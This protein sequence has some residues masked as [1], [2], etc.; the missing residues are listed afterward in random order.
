MSNIAEFLSIILAARYGKDVRQSIHD[1][2]EEVDRVADTAQNSATASAKA[3]AESAQ[4]A[5]D[6][7]T[8]A[9]G[10]AVAASESAQNAANSAQTAAGSATAAAASEKNAATSAQT[11]AES[12][13]AAVLSEKNA[14]ESAQNASEGASAAAGSASAASVSEQNAENSAQAAAESEK[15][16]EA[17]AKRVESGATA[18]ESYAH[19]GT[20]TRENE[21]VDNARYYK[22]QAERVAEGLKGCLLPMGTIPFAQLPERPKDGYMYNISDEFVTT[23]RFKEGAGHTIPAGT[24][25]YYTADGFWDCMAGSPVTGVKGAKEE[26]YRQGNISLTPQNIGALPED[27]NAVSATKAAQDG[28]GRGIADTYLEKNGDTQN[29]TVTFASADSASPAAWENIEVLKSGE[30]HSS[31]FGKISIMVKNVRYLYR[32]LGTSDISKIGDGT[33]TGAISIINGHSHDERYVKKSGDSM[34]GALNFANV[35]NRLGD[36]ALIG[37]MDHSGGVCIRGTNGDTRLMLIGR[38][39]PGQYAEIKYIS[40]K[41][42]QIKNANVINLQSDHGLQVRN[43]NNTAWQHISASAFNQISSKR[44]KKNI[45]GMGED[46]ARQVLEYRPVVYD[47]I[48]ESDGTGCMGLIAEEVDEIN[49]YPVTYKDGVP[50]ALDY[51]KFV[52]QIIKMLQIHEREITDLKKTINRGGVMSIREPPF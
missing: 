1:A 11:A 47:Y 34:N 25:V 23:D 46:V 42:L 14:S 16:A 10:S 37:D 6:S 43:A 9:A 13:E 19:G 2:I 5:G 51:S 7:A 20:G 33:V 45:N 50:D 26:S 8:A 36:D 24:N 44:Y 28:N 4:R 40:G 27:G 29:N 49:K 18:A 22:E 31:I 38:E 35:M 21:E 48:N 3:A 17:S 12:A 39:D 52:P 32:L 41:D 15:N 30:R